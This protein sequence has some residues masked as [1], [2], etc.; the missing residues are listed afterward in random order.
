MTVKIIDGKSVAAEV[1]ARLAIDVASFTRRTGRAPG[2]ATILV[3]EDPASEVYVANKRKA[4]TTAGIADFHHHLPGSA[5]AEEIAAIIDELARN[6][7]VSGIL[8]QLP[9]PS[10]T[11]ASALIDRI[12]ASKDVDGLTTV[13]AGL[14]ARGEPGLRPC[15]PTGI[16]TLLDSAN[17]PIEGSVAVVI[18]RSQLVGSPVAQLLLRRN[19]TVIIAHSRTTNLASITKQADILVAAAGIPALV[20]SE[21]VKPGAAVID[22]GIHRTGAGLIG[23]VRFDEVAR[24]AGWITPVPGGVGPMTIATLLAN[25]LHAAEAIFD[26]H[27]A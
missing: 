14:L 21:H 17:V 7:D 11:D 8:L 26:A 16:I 5:T 22:V 3:G 19:A 6:N 23:D 15:T 13:S 9:L 12:P 4:A 25:T 27:A 2:L 18:G 20:T 24:V 1:R 10:G